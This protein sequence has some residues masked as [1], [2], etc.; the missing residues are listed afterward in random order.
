MSED[1]TPNPVQD[2]RACLVAIG[3]VETRLQI[4]NN[5]IMKIVYALLG[6]I[7]A[8][9]GTKFIG[10]PW[11]VELSM[12]SL[13]FG[14]VFVLGITVMKRHCLNF[15]E[16]WIRYSFVLL[17]FWVTILR[18]YHYQTDTPFTKTEGVVTQMI[19]LSMAFGFILLAWKRDAARKLKKRRWDDVP[20]E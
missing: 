14:A 13:M 11:Y 17:A 8:N 6:V 15:W 20:I 3:K 4:L 2:C 9:V 16:K 5:N 1:Q 7:G 18:I 10:T 19:T 12:Y